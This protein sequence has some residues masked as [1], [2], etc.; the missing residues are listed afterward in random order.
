MSLGRVKSKEF[1]PPSIQT[2]KKDQNHAGFSLG[3]S[4]DFFIN[5]RTHF[6]LGVEQILFK[7]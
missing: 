7:I 6:P 5:M 1:S 3:F 2:P 4:S